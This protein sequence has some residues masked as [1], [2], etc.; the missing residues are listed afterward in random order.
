[1]DDYYHKHPNPTTEQLQEICDKIVT[2]GLIFHSPKNI[3]P[4]A[5]AIK[6][7]LAATR[8]RQYEMENIREAL[9]QCYNN[10]GF[11]ACG[12]DDAVDL[13]CISSWVQA[14]D[15]YRERMKMIDE[16]VPSYYVT[17]YL[18]GI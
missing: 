13:E 17:K 9:N 14:Q 2:R 15:I 8:P 18:N 1:M 12:N 3:K 11:C 4:M 6:L 7:Y 10:A 5:E 16:V